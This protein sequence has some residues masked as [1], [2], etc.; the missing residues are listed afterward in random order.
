MSFSKFHGT[1]HKC[2]KSGHSK[3]DCFHSEPL[4]QCHDCGARVRNI[5]DHRSITC[6]NTRRVRRARNLQANV[7]VLA[8]T[9]AAMAAGTL[10]TTSAFS[11][12]N[13]RLG[14][15]SRV[16]GTTDWYA[17]ID[18][19]ASMT[20]ARL[21]KAKAALLDDIVP[22]MHENDRMALITFD[23][24]AYFKLK[25][26]AIGQLRRQNELAPL[27]E[28][29]FTKG[30]TALWD[31]IWITVAQIR[32]KSRRTIITVL[33]DGEDNSSTHTYEQVLALIDSHPYVRLS[34]VHVGRVAS[35]QYTEVARRARGVYRLVGESELRLTFTA[36]FLNAYNVTI[37]VQPST[38]SLSLAVSGI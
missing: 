28:R 37:A 1:C 11:F 21:E 14:M 15:A 35:T 30:C 4:K 34:I 23:T 22:T 19:S 13:R 25:P 38:D 9:T 17:L 10:P 36:A 8:A 24:Q 3:K 7:T 5:M 32:D 27:L 31:A 18:V 33:T 26:R 12:A 29:I 6:P 20:G 2:G 16:P